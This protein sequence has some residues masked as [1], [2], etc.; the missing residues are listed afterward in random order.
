MPAS[1]N[2]IRRQ[3]LAY[4]L[5]LGGASYQ[6]I[7]DTLDPETGQPLYAFPSG[8]HQAVNAARRR[9]TADIAKET[10]EQA[11]ALVELEI[12][13]LDRL[14]RALWPHALRGDVQAAREIRQLVA[15]R[16]KLKLDAITASAAT[17]PIQ[18]DPLDELQ[19]RRDRR[20]SD[21]VND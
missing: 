12:A 13:R 14:Q 21:A 10:A 11:E 6:E 2:A 20:R 19:A 9:Y 4:K 18:G 7:A 5:H 15:A 16:A 17:A 3:D 1:Q 8:A